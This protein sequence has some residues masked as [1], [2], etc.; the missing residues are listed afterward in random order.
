MLE[1]GA[2]PLWVCRQTG[3]SLEM[4]EKHCGKATVVADELDSL[5]GGRPSGRLNGEIPLYRNGTYPEPSASI[6]TMPSIA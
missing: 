3:T 2:K 1:V 5:I 4:N 6:E